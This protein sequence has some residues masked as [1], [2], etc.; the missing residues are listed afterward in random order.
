MYNSI[1]LKKSILTITVS[2]LLF[3][4]SQKMYYTSVHSEEKCNNKSN[5]F[6]YKEQCW[7]NFENE[8]ISSNEIDSIVTQ[9]IEIIDQSKIKLNNEFYPI[10]QFFPYPEGKDLLLI[11]LYT[12][13]EQAYTLLGIGKKSMLRKKHFETPVILFDKDILSYESDNIKPV[14]K[15]KANYSSSNDEMEIEGYIIEENTTDT[16]SFQFTGNEALSGAGTSKIEIKNNE[17]YLSGDLGTITYQQIKDLIEN[18]PLIK[19][20]VLTHISGSVN[21]AVICIPAD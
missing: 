21:D 8:G 16:V 19:T 12:K 9:Q 3:S 5:G 11:T 15:G 17:A 1:S 2:F 13:K 7:K 6:W 10:N 14:A 18:H 4:C 20:L